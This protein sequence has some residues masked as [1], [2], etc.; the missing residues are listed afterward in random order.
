MTERRYSD[1]EVAA[2]FR[3]ATE[4]QKSGSALQR[5]DDDG[6]TLAELQTIGREVGLAPEV[7]ARAALS[8]DLRPLAGS[9]TFMGLPIGVERSISLERRLTDDEWEALVGE[10]RT[11][12]RAKGRIGGAGNFREWS[13]GNLHAMLEP[14][15]DGHRLRITTLMGAARP[16]IFAGLALCGSAAC[17]WMAAVLAGRLN[18]GSVLG[19]GFLALTGITIVVATAVHLPRWA[20]VRG[21]QMDEIV[22][23]AAMPRLPADTP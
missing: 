15:P 4:G 6:L 18:A 2:I 23:S 16:R 3:E 9:R 12:F 20:R 21:R 5:R 1:E 7:V 22:A 13:N 10:L 17:M 8:L 11:T 14:T 19:S